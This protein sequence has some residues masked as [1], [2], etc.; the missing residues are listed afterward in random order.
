[1]AIFDIE[2]DSGAARSRPTTSIAVENSRGIHRGLSAKAFSNEL[3][4]LSRK[5]KKKVK[6]ALP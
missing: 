3:D 2:A 6:T 4:G 5:K 1:L